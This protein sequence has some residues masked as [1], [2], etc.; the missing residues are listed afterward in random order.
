MAL[1]FLHQFHTLLELVKQR[2]RPPTGNLHWSPG[3]HCWFY[4]KGLGNTFYKHQNRE[5]ISV[6]NT[7]WQ[8]SEAAMQAHTVAAPLHF[9]P[10]DMGGCISGWWVRCENNTH[11]SLS[12]HVKIAAVSQGVSFARLHKPS[13]LPLTQPASCSQLEHRMLSENKPALALSTEIPLPAILAARE[14]L[15]FHGPCR[16]NLASHSIQHS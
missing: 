5:Q 6:R 13:A 7:Q 10:D 16:L 1:P 3:S 11:S 14:K 12:A 9:F 15:E 4:P 8:R 2:L